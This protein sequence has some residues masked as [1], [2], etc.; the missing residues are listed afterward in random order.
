MTE[1]SDTRRLDAI[2]PVGSPRL[3][4]HDR[5]RGLGTDSG[6]SGMQRTAVNAQS[7]AMRDLASSCPDRVHPMGPLRSRVIDVALI[8]SAAGTIS[9]AGRSR[10]PVTPLSWD[11]SARESAKAISDHS[12]RP[13]I[14]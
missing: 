14:L 10:I 12:P 8:S 6:A 11:S 3:A 2:L 9:A 13:E 7:R 4:L 1:F 5:R